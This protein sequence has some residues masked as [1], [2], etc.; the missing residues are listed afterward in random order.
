MKRLRENTQCI[1]ISRMPSILRKNTTILLL[2]GVY[3][4]G[5]MS[6]APPSTYQSPRVLKPGERV[7]GVGVSIARFDQICPIDPSIYY[8]FGLSDR[9]D[10]GFKLFAFPNIDYFHYESPT[11]KDALLGYSL[12]ID[13][14]Y[15]FIEKPLVSGDIG[16]WTWADYFAPDNE[17]TGLGV[18]PLLLLGRERAYGGIGFHYAR[19][20]HKQ[21]RMDEDDPHISVSKVA[22]P[23]VLMGAS[24]S[25][26]K[27]QFNPALNLYFKPSLS[28]LSRTSIVAEIGIQY[29]FSKQE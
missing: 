5:L 7:L 16:F 1:S 23:R 2:S 3:L 22:F 6:C 9:I 21:W 29:T 19:I 4:L 20:R 15:S 13:T 27:F 17:L 18:H 10:M 25:W 11:W 8:R 26:R 14:K 12:F 24:F 28:K